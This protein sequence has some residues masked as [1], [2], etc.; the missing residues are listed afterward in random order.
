MFAK[1]SY[2]LDNDITKMLAKEIVNDLSFS[3]FT[4]DIIE[5]YRNE[6]KVTI[7]T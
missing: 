3:D 6:A 7:K 1:Y 2:S 4:V 5:N